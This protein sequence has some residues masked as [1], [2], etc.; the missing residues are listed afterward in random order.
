MSNNSMSGVLSLTLLAALWAGPFPVSAQTPAAGFPQ[1]PFPVGPPPGVD[2]PPGEPAS[3]DPPPGEPDREAAPAAPPV[4]SVLDAEGCQPIAEATPEIQPPAGTGPVIRAVEI[5][6]PT[7]GNASSIDFETYLY[8]IRTRGSRPSVSAW[9]P[10]N[11][12]AEDELVEDFKRLWA[13]SFLDD[14]AV[15]VIDTTYPNGEIGKYVRIRMEE[16]QRVKIVE[17]V[18]S[19]RI[20]ST[21]VDEKLR[22][23][24]NVIRLDSFIDPA[25]I[26]R[27]ETV[28][29]E[30]LAE[31]GY[32]DATVSHRIT[33]IAGGPKLV[34]LSFTIEDG[35]KVF[36]R[37]VEFIG[38]QAYGDRKLRGRMKENKSRGML[39]FLSGKGTYQEAK[40]DEDAESVRA[41]YRE[42]GYIAARV[43][44]P[45]IRTLETSPDGSKRWI[46]LRIPVTEGR[47][48]RVGEFTFEG[49]TVVN[50]EALQPVF[51][52]RTGD[53]YSEKKI[54]KGLEKARELYGTGGYF[55]F[56]GYPD[57]RPRDLMDPDNPDQFLPDG[58]PPSGPPVVD[59]TMRMQEGEQYFVNTITFIGNSTTRDNVI[60][61]EMNLLENGVFNTE[62]LKFSVKR[63][64]QLGY[65]KQ[66]EE[67]SP[68]GID[69]Q[70]TPGEKNKVDV[71][72]KLQEQ[73]RNQLTFGAGVSQFEGFFGQAAF[74]TSNFMGR[75][76]T[77]SV[78]VA[79]GARTQFYQVAFTEPYLFDRPI[80]AGVDV[81]KRQIQYIGAFTQESVGGNTMVGFRTGNFT[82]SFMQYSY[83]R[84]RIKDLFAAFTDPSLGLV[85]N[86]PFLQDS[87]L[88]QCEDVP[89]SE[90]NPAGRE[91]VSRGIRT[92]SK[93]VP[94]LVHNTVD[95]PIFPNTGKRFTLSMD[96]AGL[97]G[98]TRFLK[99]RLEAVKFFQQ[100]RR[101]SIG[102][103]A[104]TEYIRP[105]GTSLPL[106]IFERLFQGG[107]YSVRGFDIRSIGPRDAGTGVVLGGNKSLL[108][109]G[110]YL[111]S[112]AGPV[113]LVMFYDAGQ[114]RN[115]GE[116]FAWSEF[117]TSTGA[118]VR[119]F[120]PVLNVPFRLIFAMN[121][122][123][124][125]I[126]NNDFR[127][128]RKFQFRFAVGSTF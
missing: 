36:I 48:Y 33:P 52:M 82:R 43:G 50:A 56:T 127:P 61:R 19:D 66:I 76:E 39:S 55:E 79:A 57:L 13:T 17:Y 116:A 87:L 80:T 110:E 45:E 117:R 90:T 101:T 74:A 40:F 21:K 59:V 10:W 122:Q 86:N 15:E 75:G 85:G 84:V 54:R 24:N 6:L 71:T 44:Q 70:K 14:L 123:R 4:R 97:G 92:V 106:P 102:V 69:V 89:V 1:V 100:S 37:N 99:P 18:G 120:M 27:V 38:N 125:G 32:M 81:F 62:A 23:I 78:S 108:F 28:I 22:E 46:Q 114:V 112:I 5:C 104:E 121:P 9:V 26:R 98:N 53:F 29:R 107:E 11:D 42:N 7:Q 12:E 96:V 30:M 128:A 25:Q 119:F 60:R 109:N 103:R 68:D 93:V 67:G 49:N 115:E 95:N 65:F 51:G 35:P 105:Y 2:E 64:N 124:D 126:L 8:Y 73:N 63:L 111:I 20:E 16:R 34:N 83:E 58:A 41:L 118:E 113:R 31:K 91:C 88:L 47:R 3:S 77:L 94:S 72:L